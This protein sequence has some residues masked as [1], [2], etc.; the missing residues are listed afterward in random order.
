[1]P[2]SMW[3]NSC[4][5]FEGACLALCSFFLSL[6]SFVVGHDV[7]PAELALI[8]PLA[9]S[10]A[11]ASDPAMQAMR[12]NMESFLVMNQLLVCMLTVKTSVTGA[13]KG[14]EILFPRGKRQDRVQT[15]HTMFYGTDFH[16]RQ[17]TSCGSAFFCVHLQSLMVCVSVV[18]FAVLPITRSPDSS[19]TRPGTPP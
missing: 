13:N 5:S 10:L 3:S 19:F 7:L 1:M 9:P 11:K 15:A 6:F 2:S 16:V 14:R 17:G 12:A 8:A 18:G 4:S